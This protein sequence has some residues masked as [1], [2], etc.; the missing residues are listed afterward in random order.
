M[1][2]LGAREALGIKTGFEWALRLGAP[3]RAIAA[4]SLSAPDL[5]RAI[6]AFSHLLK[7]SDA[8]LALLGRARDRVCHIEAVGHAVR[9]RSGY[10]VSVG[11]AQFLFC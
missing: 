5:H 6:S 10:L 9:G 3:E 1:P 11:S 4:D 2:V 7:E 8:R